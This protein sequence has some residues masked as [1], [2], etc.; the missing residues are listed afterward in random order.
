MRKFLFT[1]AVFLLGQLFV[2]L[3]LSF[4][5]TA[6]A[7]EVIWAKTYGGYATE[8]GLGICQSSDGGYVIVGI[9]QSFG[10]GTQIYMLKTDALGDTLW[11]KTYGGWDWDHGT[12]VQQTTDGGYVIVGWTTSFGN[13]VQAYLVKTDSRGDTLW[14]R[15]YGGPDWDDAIGVHQTS[16][17]GYIFTGGT[18]SYGAGNDDVYLVKTDPAGVTEW[19][20]TYG[21]IRDDTGYWVEQTED[22]GYIVCGSTESFAPYCGVYFL[23][24]DSLGD[25][26]WTR[27]WDASGCYFALGEYADQTTDGCY[28]ATGLSFCNPEPGYAEDLILIKIDA[29][30]DTVWTRHFGGDNADAGYAVRETPDGGYLA[31]GPTGSFGAGEEDVWVIKTDSDGDT[32]WTRVYGGNGIDVARD[33]LVDS[34]GNYLVLGWTTSWGAGE[35][36]MYLLKIDPSAQFVRGDGNG[37]GVLNTSDVVYLINYLFRDGS[38]PEPLVAGDANCDVSVDAADVIYLINY[39]F[40]GGPKPGCTCS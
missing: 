21:G 18:Y 8:L 29:N 37:D 26:L 5:S 39:L 14:T 24:T 13:W 33:A 10:A 17:G 3:L 9:T 35:S 22:G 15:T 19:T 31:V 7:Q 27:T 6:A 23:K 30:G 28:I 25:T 20:K 36:D 4:S 34:D 12:A 11:T 1:L 40:T 38:P 32:L 16:D 2:F